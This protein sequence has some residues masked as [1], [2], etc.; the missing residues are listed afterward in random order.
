MDSTSINN[1]PSNNSPDSNR[2]VLETKEIKS[3]QPQQLPSGLPNAGAPSSQNLSQESINKIVRGIQD[4]AGAGMTTLPSS[5]IPMTTNHV[6]QD[7]QVKPNFIPE[8]NNEDY[9]KAH[10]DYESVV[11]ENR[12]R[13]NTTDKLDDLYNEIQMPILV[14]LLFFVFQLPA[15]QSKIKLLFPNLFLKDGHP[16]FLGYLFKTSLF[17]LGFYGIHKL[18]HYL[19][20]F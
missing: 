16:T 19:S 10:D 12:G 8:A 15:V 6:V 11:M 3:P 20:E 2:V 13:Q 1:L 17:G 14:M 7:Q 18:T 5:H 4:A 9:I